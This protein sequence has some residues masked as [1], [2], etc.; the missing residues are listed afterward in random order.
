MGRIS[1]ELVEFKMAEIGISSA[2]YFA[3]NSAGSSTRNIDNSVE[4]ISLNKQ[5]AHASD[6][7]AIVSMANRFNLDFFGMNA[8][9]KNIALA[10]GY[11][12]TAIN[13]LD[14]SSEIIFKLNEIAVLAN[15]DV[16]TN[17]ETTA[18]N[19]EI[20]TLS[21]ELDRLVNN[22]T[23]KGKALFNSANTPIDLSIG[24]GGQKLTI[25]SQEIDYSDLI[26]ST[27]PTQ[28]LGTQANPLIAGTT[29]E[30]VDTSKLTTW[31]NNW[32]PRST[33]ANVGFYLATRSDLQSA[34]DVVVGAVFT[35]SSNLIALTDPLG[36]REPSDPLLDRIKLVHDRIN[37]AK[38]KIGSQ[39]TAL[40]FAADSITDIS[41]QTILGFDLIDRLQFTSEASILAK[42]QLMN[43]V[44]LAM[45]TQANNAQKG[46]LDLV[47]G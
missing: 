35:P 45:L 25:E 7:A 10:K 21:N 17:D 9:L 20:E 1:L 41:D 26:G 30:I 11:L 43:Q 24:S 15:N 39:Y 40:E 4:R 2:S 6:S 32:S 5:N 3:Q 33:L 12:D 42:N 28:Y 38:V 47:A 19:F 23:Y 36:V 44:A 18:L 22:S 16:N 27:N 46:L 34:D 8:G 31:I 37:D 13:A 14:R 29:Y